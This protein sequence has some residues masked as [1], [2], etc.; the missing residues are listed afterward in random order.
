MSTNESRYNHDVLE[1]MLV[2]NY[3]NKIVGID[4]LAIRMGPRNPPHTPKQYQVIEQKWD[5]VRKKNPKAFSKNFLAINGFQMEQHTGALTLDAYLSSYMDWSGTKAMPATTDR[6]WCLGSCGL[7]YVL[8]EGKKLFVFGERTSATLHVGGAYESLPGGFTNPAN[9]GDIDNPVITTLYSE[10]LEEVGVKKD[11]VVMVKPF[12]FGMLREWKGALFQDTCV[13]SLIHIGLDAAG[14]RS[15]FESN[16]EM[17]RSNGKT[18]EHT[19]M[20]LVPESDLGP[21]I[22]QYRTRMGVRTLFTLESYVQMNHIF[23]K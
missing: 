21:F 1:S 10:L 6:I 3:F 23:G 11:Q 8:D 13:N 15:A 22:E 16:N 18:I 7:A 14:V 9:V 12:S 19:Q 20:T 17:K 5:E 2:N 4:S